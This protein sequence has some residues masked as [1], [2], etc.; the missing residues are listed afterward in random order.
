MLRIPAT[1]L[2]STLMRVSWLPPPPLLHSRLFLLLLLFLHPTAIISGCCG[3]SSRCQQSR[4]MG[5]L[6][7][8]WCRCSR[9][10][11]AALQT[12]AARSRC[13]PPQTLQPLVTSC[14]TCCPRLAAP[15]SLHP[16]CTWLSLLQ[17]L[18]GTRPT[19]T[20]KVFVG[21]A[22]RFLVSFLHWVLAVKCT[23]TSALVCS[24]HRFSRM[25]KVTNRQE[26]SACKAGGSMAKQH[27]PSADDHD[28]FCCCCCCCFCCCCCCCCWCCCCCCA[29]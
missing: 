2:T 16:Q 10:L 24:P 1:L 21:W 4:G 25:N 13:A 20:K 28:C 29:S 11:S 7:R 19:K 14:T 26:R 5:P 18:L 15:L 22:G 12:T 27:K 23:H 17:P 9:V 6:K 8:F 3:C